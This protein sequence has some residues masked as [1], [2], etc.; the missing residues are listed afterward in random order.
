MI[1]R[2]AACLALVLALGTAGWRAGEALAAQQAAAVFAGGC[3]WCM[4]PAFDKVP[5]VISTTA[6]YTGG[7]AADATYK[8][9]SSGTTTHF[10]SVRVVYDPDKVSYGQLLQVFWHN[11]DPYDPTGQFCDKGRQYRAAIFVG[12]EAEKTLAEQSKKELEQSGAKPVATEILA[13]SPFYPAEEYH[14]DYYR[15]NPLRY[16]FYR[17]TCGRDSRLSEVW[18]AAAT[19]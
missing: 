1:R 7:A 11:I 8:K 17:A 12:N 5:G 18:G 4:E 14:Q 15:K 16:R 10:E 9:V 6:G 13:A 3:F 19:H 2:A